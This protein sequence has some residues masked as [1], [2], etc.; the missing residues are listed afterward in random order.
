[1]LD[2][3]LPRHRALGQVLFRSQHM[4]KLQAHRIA[5]RLKHLGELKILSRRQQKMTMECTKWT[6]T[7]ALNGKTALVTGGSRGRVAGIVRRR[8]SYGAKVIFTYTSSTA[9]A[10]ALVVELESEG[11]KVLRSTQT[12]SM[13]SRFKALCGGP[14]SPAHSISSSTAPLSWPLAES[15]TSR[16]PTSTASSPSTCKLRSSASRRPQR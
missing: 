16:W 4:Y 2:F 9:A 7:K 11:E 5:Q 13:P 12:G 14:S 10:Q 1:M 3:G 6:L 15:Q 8:A